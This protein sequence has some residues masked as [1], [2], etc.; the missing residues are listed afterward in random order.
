MVGT[1]VNRLCGI[2]FVSFFIHNII[3]PIVK[4]QLKPSAR[5]IGAAYNTNQPQ[6]QAASRKPQAAVHKALAASQ[7]DRQAG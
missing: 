4:T 2:L 7:A 6:P 3:L 5:A 1:Q